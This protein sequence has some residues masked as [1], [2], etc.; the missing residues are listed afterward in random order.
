MPLRFI[1]HLGLHKTGTTAIQNALE[2]SRDKL[3]ERGICYWRDDFFPELLN[4]PD[5]FP[6][7][8]GERTVPLFQERFQAITE[9]TVI[10]SSE[11]LSGDPVESYANYGALLDTMKACLA[12]R[13]VKLQIVLFTRRQDRFIEAFYRQLVHAGDPGSFRDFLATLN[14]D[15]FGWSDKLEQIQARFPEAEFIVVPYEI[16]RA[17]GG[18]VAWFMN[19]CGLPLGADDIPANLYGNQG[20]TRL[21]IEFARRCFQ[22]LAWDA[23]ERRYFGRFLQSSDAAGPDDKEEF[24]YF[25]SGERAELIERF[26]DDHARLLKWFTVPADPAIYAWTE[27]DALIRVVEQ[28]AALDAEALE[29]GV[30]AAWKLGSQEADATRKRF[31]EIEARVEKQDRRIE[32]LWAQLEKAKERNAE[33]HA[34]LKAERTK[35]VNRRPQDR[36]HGLKKVSAKLKDAWRRLRGKAAS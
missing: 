27:R 21:G 36:P 20:F 25:T 13:D 7:G 26:K 19:L 11:C 32:R 33:L 8:T 10:L 29:Y 30:A 24:G 22:R 2:K 9:D 6:P 4:H 3:Q 23:A 18:S 5:R 35:A 15:A 16:N 1:L 14:L 31:A 28:G 12:G 34:K 17:H